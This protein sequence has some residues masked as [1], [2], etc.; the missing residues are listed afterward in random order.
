[1]SSGHL[2]NADLAY[3]AKNLKSRKG[4]AS[5]LP[6]G[7]DTSVTQEWWWG[8]VLR[9]S[10]KRGFQLGV[11]SHRYT[12]FLWASPRGEGTQL[13]LGMGPCPSDVNF[14][15]HVLREPLAGLHV[16]TGS[17]LALGLWVEVSAPQ[18]LCSVGPASHSRRSNR[19]LILWGD[20][21]S[22]PRVSPHSFG[23]Q[24]PRRRVKVWFWEKEWKKTCWWLFFVQTPLCSPLGRDPKSVWLIMEGRVAV[25]WWASL[26]SPWP[27]SMPGFSGTHGGAWCGWWGSSG[28]ASP[29]ASPGARHGEGWRRRVFRQEVHEKRGSCLPPPPGSLSVVAWGQ[30]GVGI[31]QSEST[32]LYFPTLPFHLPPKEARLDIPHPPHLLSRSPNTQ[33]HEIPFLLLMWKRLGNMF[34]SRRWVIWQKGRVRWGQGLGARVL[35]DSFRPCCDC[36]AHGAGGW[37]RPRGSRLTR[38]LPGPWSQGE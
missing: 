18:P 11:S 5:A 19:S 6:S 32:S 34:L 30:K 9:V 36:K 14:L 22:R 3:L 7:Q 15:P 4:Q 10:Q 26:P 17:V 35:P 20:W 8:D 27:P 29:P 28:Q 13:E 2:I 24:T 12:S 38:L 23:L 1:M 25:I 37:G 21:P 16:I 33:G 31:W